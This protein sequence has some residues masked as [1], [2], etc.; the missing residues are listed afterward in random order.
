MAR[1]A[2]LI[3]L[4]FV[5]ATASA[6]DSITYY[7]KAPP[8]S[9]I[10]AIVEF[11][12]YS[13]ASMAAIILVLQL[14]R[15]WMAAWET[16]L[17]THYATCLIAEM[18]GVSESGA[19]AEVVP[20]P[21]WYQL[22]RKRVLRE[23]LLEHS[24]TV[25]GPEKAFLIERYR[26]FGFINDDLR[27]THSLVW[28]RRLRALSDL[29]LLNDQEFA[30]IYSRMCHD[31]NSLVSATAHLALS[32]VDHPLNQPIPVNELPARV[33]DRKN[34]LHE[35]L[36]NWTKQ[37]GHEFLI[38]QIPTVREIP[39]LE[40]VTAAVS[41]LQTPEVAKSFA[42]VLERSNELPGR[43]VEKMLT[44]LK[45][46]GDPDYIDTARKY[47]SHT[48]EL[49]RL[50]ALEYIASVD[51]EYLESPAVLADRSVLIQ[52]WVRSRVGRAA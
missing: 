44:L 1:A 42:E 31:R 30:P 49:V 27:G 40:V 28:W 21:R 36:M 52:R 45:R 24:L 32:S 17:K 16:R 35:V 5:C 18:L 29:R 11:Q 7:L 19:A 47:V 8:F 20:R 23:L 22:R 6:A 10:V 38:E 26:S 41:Q 33:R 48:D 4:V 3:F 50:R 43:V 51:F 14:H 46:V 34:L 39:V 13:L 25:T 9:S 37:F 12:F 15:N 2:F